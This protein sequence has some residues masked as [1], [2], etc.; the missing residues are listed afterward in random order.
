M[1][2]NA[3]NYLQIVQQ[4]RSDRVVASNKESRQS[5]R[6]GVSGRANILIPAKTGTKPTQVTVRDLS[7]RGVGLILPTSVLEKGDEFLLLLPQG[8]EHTRRAMLFVVRRTGQ[9]DAT[10]YSAGG[11]FVREVPMEPA[12]RPGVKPMVKPTAAPVNSSS[13]TRGLSEQL[14]AGADAKAV[15]ELQERLRK[16]SA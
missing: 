9:V 14:L 13:I 1:Q 15:Q 7:A 11:E 5:P 12:P 6:V 10:L 3:D 8:K 4:L 2:L 16:M